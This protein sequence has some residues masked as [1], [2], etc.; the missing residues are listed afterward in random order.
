MKHSNTSIPKLGTFKWN[1]DGN[2]ILS[3]NGEGKIPDCSCGKNPAAQW[4]HLK[5]RIRKIHIMEG[6]TEIGINAFRGCKNLERVNLPKSLERIHAYAF[7][8]CEKLVSLK[9]GRTS[10]RYIYDD[11]ACNKDDTIVFGVESF[12]AVPWS[13]T[14]WGDFYINQNR[15]YVTFSNRNRNLVVPEGVRLLKASSMN[16]LDVD[17]IVLPST[18]EMIENFAFSGSRVK[19]VV[20]LPASVKML[21]DYALADCSIKWESS[22]ILVEMVKKCQELDEQERSR[23]PS[24]FK[25]YS[26]SLAE[27]K[28]YGGFKKLKITEKRPKDAADGSFASFVMD[29]SVDVGKSI[30]R[31]IRTGN[32][33][34]CITWEDGQITSVKSFAYSNY[35]E[36]PNEYLMYPVMDGKFGLS[37]WEDSFTYQE[38]ADIIYAFKKQ[39]GRLMMQADGL[40]QT[41]PDV[42]EEWF[43]SND[44]DNF[45][46]PLE[47][48]L[49]ERWLKK[50]PGV[51]V[52]SAEAN[53]EQG[54]Y[55]WFVSV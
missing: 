13:R 9:G 10:F 54:K 32:V 48:D 30:Y 18:L 49:L 19:Q 28:T 37:I 29:D 34:L 43:W 47:L 7:W 40:R 33:V 25:H 53:K 15:L 39:N 38:P 42:H 21:S 45:G 36:T 3:I 16:H 23:F 31:R 1:L 27:Q 46:G 6:I 50:N 24:F 44:R 35:Y 22:P 14:K 26:V 52:M 51:T 41:S 5:D 20:T 4:D 17:S 2:G 12:Y 11:A 55:R 8:G